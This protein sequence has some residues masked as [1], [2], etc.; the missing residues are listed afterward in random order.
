VTVVTVLLP[1]T[2]DEKGELAPGFSAG[3]T[4]VLQNG[5]KATADGLTGFGTPDDSIVKMGD[6]P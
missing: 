2:D 3:R 1:E 4:P 5:P 6:R